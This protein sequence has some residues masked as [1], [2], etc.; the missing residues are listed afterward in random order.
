MTTEEAN[1]PATC[2][3]ITPDI[4]GRNR[5]G[6]LIK[7]GRKYYLRVIVHGKAI[8]KSL[9][10]GDKDEAQRRR[11]GMLAEL[12]VTARGLAETL[13]AVR[14]KLEGAAVKA[15]RAEAKHQ[16]EQA[17]RAAERARK[18]LAD[19]WALYLASKTRPQTGEATLKIYGYWWQAF[20]R[21]L[22]DREVNHLSELTPET[23]QDYLGDLRT[24][25]LT[26]KS[27]RNQFAVLKLVL[28]H[29][30]A[31]ES[32]PAGLFDWITRDTIKG[33]QQRRQEI[34]LPKLAE[35]CEKAQG[36]MKLLLF[37]G[38][39]TGLRLKDCCTLQWSEVD[40]ARGI[41]TRVPA[42]IAS[43]NP[44]PLR[45]PVHRD[46][47]PMLL[48]TPADRRKG[49]VLPEMARLH[50][51]GPYRVTTKVQEHLGAC[52]LDL[53]YDTAENRTG[54]RRALRFGFHSLRHSAATLWQRA[55]APQHE[56]AEI[57]GHTSTAMTQHYSHSS[58]E[59]MRRVVD[60][61]PTI[62]TTDAPKQLPPDSLEPLRDQ[63]RA[64]LPGATEAQLEAALAVL[65]PK[66]ARD[67]QTRQ[68]RARAAAKRACA[69]A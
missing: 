58:E 14:D 40:T 39:Y 35:I 18:P 64:A 32:I 7:R 38:I 43:R 59:T 63:V 33:I 13:A 44:E 61:M 68:P 25:K 20:A 23:M 6:T 21:W 66:P 4:G 60:S 56:V 30:P 36:E 31:T 47:L 65:L 27:Q 24:G 1:T 69:D 41:I 16:V 55:G 52:G 17:Q 26:A 15:A 37:L 12:G 62:G 57:L 2:A 34:P 22:Q 46:L 10:T 51:A 9:G 8:T 29:L 3:D 11:P 28:K 53:Y 5:T 67:R 19:T 49:D 42:K 45:I 48:E 50:R 54:A